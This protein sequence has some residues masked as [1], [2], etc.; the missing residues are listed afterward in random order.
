[1]LSLEKAEQVLRAADCLFSAEDVASAVENMA[2]AVTQDYQQKNPL[3]LCVMKGGAFTA[4]AMLQHLSF[5]LEFDYMQVTRYRNTT[6]GGELEWRIK[7]STPMQ[8]RHVLIVDDIYDEGVTLAGVIEYCK[9]Q[10]VASVCVAVLTRKLH[11]RAV[12]IPEVKYIGMDIPDR[13][14]FGCGMDY[15]GYFRNLN[16]IYALQEDKG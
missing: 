7:P 3:V 14:V 12:S 16:T 11:D 9:Q 6:Q 4:C 10:S 5:P 8:G 1:M 15:E 13:Y 2:Q